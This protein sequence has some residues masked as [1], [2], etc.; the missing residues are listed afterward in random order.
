VF[1]ELHDDASHAAAEGAAARAVDLA[2][3]ALAVWRGPALADVALASAGRA[4]AERLEEL[5]LRTHELRFDAD[6]ELGRHERVVSQLQSLVRQNPYRERFVAQ[7][8]LALYRTGRHADALQ[9]YEQT[10]RRLDEDL[11]LQPSTDLQQLSGQIVR[12]DPLLRRPPSTPSVV[13]REAGTQKLRRAAVLV[14]AGAVVAAALALTASGGAS[15]REH[16]TPTA[17]RLALVLPGSPASLGLPA[18]GLSTAVDSGEI[19]YELQTQTASVDPRVPHPDVAAVASRIRNGGVGLVVVLGDGP[20][21][22]ALAG[23]V[24]SLPETRFVFVDA[25]LDALSLEGM[26]NAA[27]I[28][29]AEEDVLYLAGYLSGLMPT[30]DRSKRRIDAASVVAGEPTR[31]TTRLI[32]GFKRGLRATRPQVKVRVDY[33]HQ[34]EDPT[35]CE[36]LSNRQINEGADVVVAIAGRCGLGA[37]EVARIRGVWGVGAVEDGIPERNNVLLATHKEWTVATLHAI[38][39]LVEGTL[40][41]GRDT[42]LGLED[43]YSA[44]LWF[45]NRVPERIASA[46]VHRCS[47]IRASRDRDL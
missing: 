34:L 37:I 24:R 43:D 25:S 11:G 14:A 45:N 27:A 28:R 32:E 30:M 10:R 38:E 18:K 2:A 41:M 5:R 44:G 17:Q 15:I 29:F 21:A 26:P 9:A 22:R 19:L 39:E 46:L 13:R 4:E 33:S 36:R 31:N 6:L 16:V 23:V 8:M 35:A 40:P 42:V 47:Q 7:L 1:V 3:A 12:Q 20:A